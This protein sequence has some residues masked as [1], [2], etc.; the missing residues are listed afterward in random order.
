MNPTLGPADA[1][2]QSHAINWTPS[3]NSNSHYLKDIRHQL[4]AVSEAQRKIEAAREDLLLKRENYRVFGKRVRRQRIEAGD[5]EA[6]LLNELRNYVNS[7]QESLPSAVLSAYE[8]VGVKRDSLGVLEDDLFQVEEA[9]T[10]SEWTFMEQETDLYQLDLQELASVITEILTS[11]GAGARGDSVSAP[12][13][14]QPPPDLSPSFPPPS[15]NELFLYPP[16]PGQASRTP[17]SS[18][19]IGVVKEPSTLHDIDT[20]TSNLNVLRREFELMRKTQ[21]KRL[22]SG[23]ASEILKLDKPLSESQDEF[24]KPD[25]FTFPARYFDILDRMAECEVQVQHLRTRDMKKD[26]AMTAIERRNSAPPLQTF[27]TPVPSEI[28]RALSDSAIPMLSEDPTSK[29]RIREWLLTDLKQ[30]PVQQ[31]LYLN[32]LEDFGLL[33]SQD[34][35]W[36]E[37]AS[38][39]WSLDSSTELMDPDLNHSIATGKTSDHLEVGA[40][41]ALLHVGY[42]P[43]SSVSDDVLH[44]NNFIP[45]RAG[46]ENSQVVGEHMAQVAHG[47]G[48][49]T[50]L[51]AALTNGTFIPVISDSTAP[52]LSAVPERPRAASCPIF[53]I[54]EH[55]SVPEHND[56]T[57]VQADS[58]NALFEPI[59]PV[60]IGTQESSQTSASRLSPVAR[61]SEHDIHRAMGCKSTEQEQL[62]AQDLF[63]P[64]KHDT[65]ADPRETSWAGP[66]AYS[67]IRMFL[68]PP[69]RPNSPRPVS[70]YETGG[71]QHSRFSQL[72]SRLKRRRRTK[73]TSAVFVRQDPTITVSIC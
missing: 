13:G 59:H 39:Y 35:D 1:G 66:L 29:H 47:C 6:E 43:S 20:A 44:T 60:T 65:L 54:S 52:K 36:M 32:T 9:L 19:W 56:H 12:P 25:R 38:H 46:I 16:L 3:Y 71:A 57:C 41:H 69:T 31:K 45:T 4:Q 49:A 26:F 22:E 61:Y 8:R 27:Y 53:Q 18:P 5:A 2:E 33:G 42:K 34:D 7:K 67:E 40:E 50:S 30:S 21:A 14:R 63:R 15:S 28:N 55:H 10:G 51:D 24:L 23:L 62:S 11:I 64:L 37:R 68:T 17:E 70:E 73:S 48:R 58:P 72:V